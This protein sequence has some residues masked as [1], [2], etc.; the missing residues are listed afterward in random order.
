MNRMNS[1]PATSPRH[2]RALHQLVIHLFTRGQDGQLPAAQQL[3]SAG[4]QEERGLA[5]RAG[6]GY[7]GG[8]LVQLVRWE[9]MGEFW[10]NDWITMEKKKLPSPTLG[11]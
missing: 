9:T 2:Q 3:R 11:S 7:G 5:V 10:E 8:D 6:G 1:P 4:G